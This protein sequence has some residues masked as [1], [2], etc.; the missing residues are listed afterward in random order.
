MVKKG[1]LEIDRMTRNA[2][3]PPPFGDCAHPLG[4]TFT[5]LYPFI[6][7]STSS[8]QCPNHPRATQNLQR[9]HTMTIPEPSTSTSAQVSPPPSLLSDDPTESTNTAALLLPH[10]A[11]FSPSILEILRDHYEK[12]GVIAHW[13]PVKAFGRVIIVWQEVEGC[14]LAKR[15][16]DY[17][18]LDV[19]LPEEDTETAQTNQ[20]GTGKEGYFKPKSAKHKPYVF[21]YAASILHLPSRGSCASRYGLK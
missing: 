15:N 18:K 16:G 17:L 14:E 20:P 13:A 10:L 4:Q 2:G 7:V 19:D 8:R 1:D 21:T 12:F 9:T 6:D 5:L 11:L 3:P